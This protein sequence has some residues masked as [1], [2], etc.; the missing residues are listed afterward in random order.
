MASLTVRPRDELKAIT[1]S[2]DDFDTNGTGLTTT[3]VV[4]FTVLK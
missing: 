4:E 3:Y 2:D 1:D